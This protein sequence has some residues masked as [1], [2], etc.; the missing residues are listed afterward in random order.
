MNVLVMYSLF[1][2]NNLIYR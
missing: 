1:F 2:L